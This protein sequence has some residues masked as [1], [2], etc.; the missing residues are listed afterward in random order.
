MLREKDYDEESESMSVKKAIVNNKTELPTLMEL[1]DSI[2][3]EENA[4]FN[5]EKVI[6]IIWELGLF[7]RSRVFI[8]PRN[9]K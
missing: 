1:F 2:G 9:E 6:R 8:R 5:S 3:F 4:V 7:D